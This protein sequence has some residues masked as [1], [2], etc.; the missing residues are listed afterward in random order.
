[1]YI[2]EELHGKNGVIKFDWSKR[3]YSTGY[4]LQLVLGA[5]IEH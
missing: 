1:M 5:R 4:L 3:I 2:K